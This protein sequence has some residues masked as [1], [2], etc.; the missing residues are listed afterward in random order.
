[1]SPES[2]ALVQLAEDLR[3]ET[4]AADRIVAEAERCVADLAS[5]APTS[6]ELR[7]AGDIVH[8][9]YNALERFLERVANEMNGGIPAGSDSHVRL[10]ERMARELPGVR[11]AVIRPEVMQ[12]LG[13]YLRFRHLFRHRYGFEIEWTKVLP[14]L[15]SMTP[16][17]AAVRQDLLAFVDVVEELAQRLG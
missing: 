15:R 14:L 6:L 5:R 4:A 8:D 17:H 11:P 16:V 7:G 2:A 10:L 9:Y 3:Y 1:M 13:E 12:S